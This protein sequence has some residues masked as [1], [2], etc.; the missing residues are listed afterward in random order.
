MHKK[1]VLCLLWLLR[2]SSH[3]ARFDKKLCDWG[4][5]GKDI[6]SMLNAVHEDLKWPSPTCLVSAGE[7]V[8]FSLWSNL[9]LRRRP[10]DQPKYRPVW[11]FIE[12]CEH[13]SPRERLALESQKGVLFR[14][15]GT[16]GCYTGCRL[17]HIPTIALPSFQEVMFTWVLPNRCPWYKLLHSGLVLLV[18]APWAV[19]KPNRKSEIQRVWHLEWST[20]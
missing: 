15:S 10:S 14:I 12:G 9:I 1:F 7:C 18:S 16:S 13:A 3:T 2:C 6:R 19:V 8:F 17:L 11:T 20:F 4:V 5:L